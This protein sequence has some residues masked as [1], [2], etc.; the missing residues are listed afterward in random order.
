MSDII[1]KKRLSELLAETDIRIP[2]IQRDY[3]Q[4]RLQ[5]PVKKIRRDFV[6]DL[7]STVKGENESLN[8]D[9]IYGS[10]QGTTNATAF[11]PLDGQQRLT[12]LFLL[13][14]LLGGEF[15]HWFT[16]ATRPSSSD[17]FLFLKNVKVADVVKEW[18]HSTE[19]F[20]TILKNQNPESYRWLWQFDPTIQGALVMLDE[21]ANNL[22]RSWLS[23]PHEE[24]L[25]R[26]ANISFEYLDLDGLGLSKSLYVKMNARGKQLS[27]FDLLKS[28]LEQDILR[29]LAEAKT[30]GRKEELLAVQKKWR[31]KVDTDWIDALWS[32]YAK[33]KIAETLIAEPN[34]ESNRKKR[35]NI[36]TDT[37]DWL[38]RMLLVFIS[39]QLFLTENKAIVGYA[40]NRKVSEMKAT[41]DVYLQGH[42]RQE[43]GDI[44]MPDIDY[45]L[46][47]ED[48]DA[49]LSFVAGEE[50]SLPKPT[51][52]ILPE[53]SFINPNKKWPSYLDY[54]TAEDRNVDELAILHAI[55][56]WLKA[57]PLKSQ[58]SA[59]WIKDFTDWTRFVRNVLLN[60]NN[61]SRL[62]SISDL[63][64]VM[65]GIDTIV[66]KWFFSD[67]MNY[68]SVVNRIA[69]LPEATQGVYGRLDNASIN[70]EITKAKM[71]V[72]DPD[73]EKLITEA[74][75]QPYVWGQIRWLLSWATTDKGID[76]AKFK[77]YSERFEKV[78]AFAEAQ[79]GIWRTAMFILN[80]S[81][82]PTTDGR[83]F[84]FNNHR[85]YSVKRYLR[86]NDK[87][88]GNRYK[89]VIDFW[90]SS[91]FSD[92][93][94]SYCNNL[95]ENVASQTPLWIKALCKHPELNY[96]DAAGYLVC[97]E[98]GHTCL[99]RTMTNRGGYNDPILK[100]IKKVLEKEYAD[101]IN[102]EQLKIW[103]FDSR[104]ETPNRID[105]KTVDNN[106]YIDREISI[107][108]GLN[109]NEYVIKENGMIRTLSDEELLNVS[110]VSLN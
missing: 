50:S 31:E 62:D 47:I 72:V 30:Q 42:R 9:F 86:Y 90:I 59:K 73:W 22:G 69:G 105:I 77:D 57:N 23:E 33:E 40:Y 25:S 34:S 103:Y 45:A 97:V 65:K 1:E 85:D 95:I 83:S 108:W 63:Q 36:A 64:E 96:E 49:V 26:L 43:P 82:L 100:H 41:F 66:D 74:E 18:F 109:D 24:A 80:H 67:G 39:R 21:I 13:Y 17:F 75:D 12:T 28:T 91:D 89:T 78:R 102:N 14:W 92:D 16:Y 44:N 7:L 101:S 48:I 88:I 61:Y 38:Q 110:F 15:N 71:K 84:L 79:I 87:I 98:K 104:R 20:S 52:L 2:R 5:E 46:L 51:I 27:D 93:I 6:Q 99:G 107:Q 29:Q 10:Y 94:A 70:E 19:D 60:N 55:I 68:I 11:E 32:V 3:A 58:E 8:L 54:L 37:E 56:L 53:N 4:G 106:G 35:K 76:K 81:D